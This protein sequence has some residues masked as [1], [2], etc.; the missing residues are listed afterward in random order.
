MLASILRKNGMFKKSRQLGL[1]LFLLACA[2]LVFAH[3][4]LPLPQDATHDQ[5]T[6]NTKPIHDQMSSKDVTEKLKKALDSKNAAYTG[7]N[8]EAVADDQTVTLT[9]TVTSSMQHEMA[10]QLARAY[11]G[12]R[13]IVDKLTIQ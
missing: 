7:S 11:A 9:G 4:P 1:C 8:I 5:N 6:P 10:L 12:S 3:P 2:S 13:K